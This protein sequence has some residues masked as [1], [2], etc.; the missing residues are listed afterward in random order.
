MIGSIDTRN[1]GRIG[2]TSLLPFWRKK[3]GH[4]PHSQTQPHHQ[5]TLQ[6]AARKSLRG[7]DRPAKSN[8]LD[9]SRRNQGPARRE[10]SAHWRS[11]SLGHESTGRRGARRRRRLSGNHSEREACFHLVVEVHAGTRVA[12]NAYLQ[13]RWRRYAHDAA[14]REILRRRRARQAPGRLDQRDGETRQISLRVITGVAY[15][16]R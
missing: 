13:A 12:R 15:A 3:H 7:V 6:R 16:A 8:A 1:S 5:A 11:L 10:R 9:G 4:H 14:A 2:W